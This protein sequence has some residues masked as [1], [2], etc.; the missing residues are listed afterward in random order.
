MCSATHGVVSWFPNPTTSSGALI[1]IANPAGVMHVDILDVDE[2][3][4]NDVVV[5]APGMAVWINLYTGDDVLPLATSGVGS[6]VDAV[7]FADYDGDGDLDVTVGA[8]WVENV[9]VSPGASPFHSMPRGIQAPSTVEG[10]YTMRTIAMG[11]VDM[12]GDV[13]ELWRTS[14]VLSRRSVVL[15]AV[16]HGWYFGTHVIVS[17]MCNGKDGVVFVDGKVD[18]RVRV[19]VC[20]CAWLWWGAVGVERVRD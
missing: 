18:M 10:G 4:Y 3:A 14:I 15:C 8:F 9:G 2:D 19:C 13:G 5:V 1:P 20:T 12:D 17:A 16:R 11:D 6:P 7:A